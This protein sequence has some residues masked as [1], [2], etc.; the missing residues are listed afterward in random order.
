MNLLL[1]TPALLQGAPPP[2]RRQQRPDGSHLRASHPASSRRPPTRLGEH[3]TPRE[4]IDLM[5]TLLLT[6][7][8]DLTVPGLIREVY[9]P[10]A[11]TGGTQPSRRTQDH[12]PDPS[13]EVNLLGQEINPASWSPPQG[14][15]GG[16]GQPIDNIVPGN[17]LTGARVPGPHVPLLP[18]QPAVRGGLEAEPQGGGAR[19]HGRGLRRPFRPGLPRVDGLLLFLMHY[20]QT[21]CKLPRTR[22]RRPAA[23]PS[24]S[25]VPPLFTGGAGSGEVEH[26]QVGPGE[27]LPEVIIGL[28]AWTC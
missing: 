3:F 21:R 28:P 11:G 23:R 7:D 25:A 27:R 2:G 18:L 15:H 10:T 19:A 6:D 26:P 13:A 14:G 17:T 9:D 12:R 8:A 4:V 22:T 24:C 20:L 16:Q 1:Q 5:V